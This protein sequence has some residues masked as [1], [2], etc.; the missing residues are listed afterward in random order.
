MADDGKIAKR[1]QIVI[2]T[3]DGRTSWPGDVRTQESTDR[4]IKILKEASKGQRTEVPM[5]AAGTARRG[6]KWRKGHKANS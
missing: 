5:G 4:A 1:A 3:I 6:S 2:K